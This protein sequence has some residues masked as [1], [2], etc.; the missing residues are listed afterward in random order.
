MVEQ[1]WDP[2]GYTTGL[3]RRPTNPRATSLSEIMSCDF[4]YLVDIDYI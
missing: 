3:D 2:C 4:H 1:A